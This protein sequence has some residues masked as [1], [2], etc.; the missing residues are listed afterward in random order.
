MSCINSVCYCVH[1]R[2]CE[3]QEKVAFVVNTKAE[4]KRLVSTKVEVQSIAKQIALFFLPSTQIT[5]PNIL[6][7]CI[8]SFLMRLF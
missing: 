5:K 2:V 4:K 1:Y 7:N 3:C 8:K 6:F